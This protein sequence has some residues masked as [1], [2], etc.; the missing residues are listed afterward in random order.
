MREIVKR[1]RSPNNIKKKP[2]FEN[3][4][5]SFLGSGKSKTMKPK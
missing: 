5:L 3:E 2:K 1:N 4:V